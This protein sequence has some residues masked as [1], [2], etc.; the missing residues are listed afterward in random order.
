MRYGLILLLA[1]AG[2]LPCSPARGAEDAKA[3]PG[4]A[5]PAP[6]NTRV[7][8]DLRTNVPKVFGNGTWQG[9]V[10]LSP[11][12]L[13]IQGGKG[14]D[15][16]GEIGQDLD[17]KLDLS[18]ERYVE[19]ALGVGIMNEVPEV[20]VAFDDADE[21]QYSARIRIDQ[22][23]PQ[24]P[25]WFRVRLTDFK[26]NN[27]QGDKASRKIDWTRISRWHLQGDWQTAAPFNVIFITL[28]TRQ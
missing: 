15:G 1:T 22:V 13:V 25:V 23:L 12:G 18:K 28:R 11:S 5:S 10:A 19:L 3:D 6:D 9:K 26:L 16:K 8:A 17:P 20:T 24:Q 21:V 7:I 27:W 4:A 14:A 2:L